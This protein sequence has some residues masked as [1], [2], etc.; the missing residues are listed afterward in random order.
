MKCK[1][2]LRFRPTGQQERHTFRLRARSQNVQS[3]VDFKLE[4]KKA[5]G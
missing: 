5:D 3:A 4:K 2:A 1:F